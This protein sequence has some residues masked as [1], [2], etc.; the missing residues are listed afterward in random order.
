MPK[1]ADK[2]PR[3]D[4]RLFYTNIVFVDPD[5]HAALAE[6]ALTQDRISE[7]MDRIRHKQF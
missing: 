3:F 4:I 2:D 6:F 7:L 5:D 1:P